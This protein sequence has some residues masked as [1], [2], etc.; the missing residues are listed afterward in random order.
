MSV[1]DVRAAV[2]KFLDWVDSQPLANHNV[3]LMS[4]WGPRDQLA[5]ITMTQ[6]IQT[7]ADIHGFQFIDTWGRCRPNWARPTTAF[8]PR[9]PEA[10]H[11][12]DMSWQTPISDRAGHRPR[13]NWTQ[14]AR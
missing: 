4:P 14:P 13:V 10:P 8:I 12:S 7:E 3:Y 11:C 2:D 9:S 5:G 6:I 1:H